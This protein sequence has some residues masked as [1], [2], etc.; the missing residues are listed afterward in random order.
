[1]D[2]ELYL[3]IM[4]SIT[5]TSRET[6]THPQKVM[7]IIA[8]KLPM[9]PESPL[10]DESQQS[11]SLMGNESTISDPPPSVR[12]VLHSCLIGWCQGNRVGR[13]SSNISFT[14]L[15]IV[16]MW[17]KNILDDVCEQ[18]TNIC[19]TTISEA[20]IYYHYHFQFY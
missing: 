2:T 6:N 12:A 13:V 15:S 7:E 19:W 17:V 1:M 5:S 16:R 10:T 20:I 3:T 11:V 8:D 4:K 14:E 9:Y 18:Q